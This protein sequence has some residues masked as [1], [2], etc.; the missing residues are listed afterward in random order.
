MALTEQP[1]DAAPAWHKAACIL[2]ESNCGI[3][4]RLEGRH[5]ARIR[6]GPALRC[7]RHPWWAPVLAITSG[8]G[9]ST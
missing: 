2:C 3:E 9:W 6:G 8:L 7:V 5:F 4:V 1:T